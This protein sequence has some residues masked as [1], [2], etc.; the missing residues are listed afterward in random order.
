MHDA[1]PKIQIRYSI[2]DQHLC[3]R[4]KLESLYFVIQTIFAQVKAL[5]GQELTSFSSFS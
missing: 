4:Y 5:A 2:T 1:N 3:F